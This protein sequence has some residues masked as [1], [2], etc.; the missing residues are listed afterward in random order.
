MIIRLC[1]LFRMQLLSRA[2]RL[3]M[4]GI[5]QQRHR[6]RDVYHYDEHNR[7][8]QRAKDHVH[9]VRSKQ[10]DEHGDVGVAMGV[11]IGDTNGMG[12][13]TRAIPRNH[14]ASP[15]RRW[16]QRTSAPT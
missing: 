13:S 7:C 14:A 4:D 8:D 6:R 12:S 5:S 15:V 2:R 16:T 9:A 10:R 11:L 3:L 1:S